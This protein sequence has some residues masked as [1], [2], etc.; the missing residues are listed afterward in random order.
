M[1]G[2]GR[3]GGGSG[4]W[5]GSGAG[6][7]GGNKMDHMLRKCDTLNMFVFLLYIFVFSI[8]TVYINEYIMPFFNFLVHTF[9]R[10]RGLRGIGGGRGVTKWYLWYGCASQY[11]ET[12]SI[13]IPGLK[14]KQKKKKQKKK[15]KK[16]KK[17]RA[18]SYTWSFE[19]MT[20]SYTVLW[21]SIPIYCW[22]LDKTLQSIHWIPRKEA[23]L[24]NLWAKN[25]LIYRDV[26]KVGPL[27]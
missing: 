25:I 16:K 18:N 6:G 27:T 13:H 15:T 12:C 9:S 10:G 14:K 5:G 23:A 22:S 19:V 1:C 3:G 26:R 24:K 20:C 8:L 4:E 21:F 11:F 2:V 17:K 7:R